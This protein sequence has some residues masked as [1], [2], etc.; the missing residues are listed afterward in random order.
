LTYSGY[1]NDESSI[2][3]GGITMSELTI[4]TNNHRRDIIYWWELTEEEKAEFDYATE[5]SMFFRYKGSLYCLDDFMRIEH[6]PN[7]D[8]ASWDGYSPDGFSSGTVVK[9]PVEDWGDLDTDYLIVGWYY[10]HS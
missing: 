1:V 2:E 9:W 6:H 3:Y 4:I 7:S 8:F 5:E 10:Y